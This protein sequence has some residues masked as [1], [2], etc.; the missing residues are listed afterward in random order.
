MSFF[1]VFLSK[2]TRLIKAVKERNSNDVK[3]MLEKGAS[4]RAKDTNGDT[5]IQIGNYMKVHIQNKINEIP[6]SRRNAVGYEAGLY[7]GLQN[8]LHKI[9]Y[10]ISQLQKT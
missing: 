7:M 1:D 4:P 3:K 9:E 10:I 5:A 2:E 8:E 6:E